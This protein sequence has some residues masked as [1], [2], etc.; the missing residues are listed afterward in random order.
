MFE[1][2]DFAEYIDR[3]LRCY[4]VNTTESAEL[5]EVDIVFSVA[6]TR[7]SSNKFSALQSNRLLIYLSSVTALDIFMVKSVSLLR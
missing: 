4:Y 1:N 3:T 6:I 5:I 2:V 7:Y